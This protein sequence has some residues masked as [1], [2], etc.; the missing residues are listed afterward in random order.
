MFR[1]IS[2]AYKKN[3]LD[4]LQ[5][6]LAYHVGKSEFWLGMFTIFLAFFLFSKLSVQSVVRLM[7]TYRIQVVRVAPTPSFTIAVPDKSPVV[8]VSTPPLPATRQYVVQ[9]NDSYFTATSRVCGNGEN[10]WFNQQL[11]G[12]RA[13]QP[14]DTLII[15][16]K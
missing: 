7:K 15:R 12:D 13:L 16:C 14:G 10:Y 5:K 2:E 6:D 9:Q 11:N 4:S 3:S 1:A 8:S